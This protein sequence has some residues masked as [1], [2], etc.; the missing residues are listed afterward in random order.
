[1]QSIYISFLTIGLIILTISLFTNLLTGFFDTLSALDSSDFLSSILPLSPL[2]VC[3]FS[4]GFGGMGITLYTY[5]SYHFII[6]IFT[7]FIL[8]F[9]TKKLISFLK[10]VNN[11]TV[12]KQDL[13][14]MEGIVI[15]TI[16]ENGIGSVSLNTKV[17]K[18]S[19]PAQSDHM[20]KQ[21]SIV[22]VLDIKEH[23]LIVSNDF[24]YFL[25]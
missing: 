3:A 6:S 18:I 5:C 4:V 2:E 21:G 8:Y 13:I 17:G 24:N 7:G 11:E 10:E 9:A 22:K 16:F 15:V 1:M 19:Y 12:N 25:K 23:T 14:G 20:I